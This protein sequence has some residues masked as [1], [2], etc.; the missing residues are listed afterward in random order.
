MSVGVSS[1]NRKLSERP[2]GRQSSRLTASGSLASRG[3]GPR[4]KSIFENSFGVGIFSPMLSRRERLPT[5]E[6]F[7]YR[8]SRPSPATR[9]TGA[10]PVEIHH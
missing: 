1:A 9:T 5:P 6:L 8:E 4:L 10:A 7:L 3:T 2:T